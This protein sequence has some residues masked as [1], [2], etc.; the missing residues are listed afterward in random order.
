MPLVPVSLRVVLATLL[1]AVAAACAQGPGPTY[2]VSDPSYHSAGPG[3]EEE[4]QAVLDSQAANIGR[5]DWRGLLD[6]F[7][8]T[9]RSRCPLARFA[10]AADESFGELR[11]RSQGSKIS[12]RMSDLEVN[13]FRA[14]V[15]Y[16][17]VL[18]AEGLA[19]PA[20]TANYLKL[21]DEWFIDEKAC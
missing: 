17:F 6:Q 21:G 1:L 14:S 19:S 4:I 8:P 12:A 3:A 13:G 20:Q 16:Q 10:E 7:I 15:D 9:E 18:P 5:G 2:Q 11:E